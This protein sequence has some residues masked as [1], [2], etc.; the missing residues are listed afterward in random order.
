M[1]EWIH[2]TL[3]KRTRLYTADRGG[4]RTVLPYIKLG[5][6]ES[7][8][9]EDTDPWIF[10]NNACKGYVRGPAGKW[11]PGDLSNVGLVA[12]ESFRSFAEELLMW[13][14]NEASKGINIGGGSNI[15]FSVTG[16]GETLKIGGSNQAH[17]KVSQDRM[18]W[19]IW[20]SQKLDVPY[21]MWTSSV[22]KDD[23]TTSLGKILGPDVIGKALTAETP[24]WFDLT[25]R[26]DV[27]PAQLGKPERHLM[28]LGSHTDVGAGNAAGL[29]N[30]RMPLAA[31]PLKET[32][33]EP[34]SI[35]KA[36]EM[37]DG[38]SDAAVEVIKKR[39][40]IA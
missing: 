40:G 32:I 37:I 20:K 16:D 5:I 23:D 38:G 18:T 35:V 2:K 26:M 36:L 30:I 17:Y 15:A 8:E 13:E 12:L 28:Y 19:E 3:K 24:R 29:G 11:V 14:A 31:P 10:L 9:I 25:L 4:T 34:A 6:I 27:I 1:A 22:S 7:V 39:L 33:I 21:V